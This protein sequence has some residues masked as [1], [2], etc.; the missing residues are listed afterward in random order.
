MLTQVEIA[1]K[2][3]EIMNSKNL[4]FENFDCK[5]L[6]NEIKYGLHNMKHREKYSDYK[7]KD[8]KVEG[9]LYI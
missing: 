4:N 9:S 1:I 8:L 3:I 5:L 7:I 2:Y 6:L